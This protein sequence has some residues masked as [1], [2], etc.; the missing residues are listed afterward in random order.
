MAAQELELFSL[1]SSFERFFA[2]LP[3]PDDFI[4]ENAGS[5]PHIKALQASI[6]AKI[7]KAE[8]A[9]NGNPKALQRIGC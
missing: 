7:W 2:S 1:L 8:L 3:N 4:E 5:Q 6:P 9:S